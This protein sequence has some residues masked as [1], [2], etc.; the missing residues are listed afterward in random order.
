M[1]LGRWSTG[2]S[3]ETVYASLEALTDMQLL[4]ATVLPVWSYVQY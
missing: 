3:S 1:L 4:L 2:A